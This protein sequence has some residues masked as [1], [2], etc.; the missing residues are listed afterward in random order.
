MARRA[1]TEDLPDQPTAEVEPA[2]R[3]P[4]GSRP[5]VAGLMLSM[6]LV[7][8]DGTVVSTAMPSIISDLGGFKFYAWVPA[9]Y[10]LCAA[11][12][13][14]IY[15]KLADLFGRKPILYV[16]IGLFLAGSITSGAAP[17]VLFL[18][19]ARS[20]QGLGAGAV[21][22]IT[23]TI[24]GDIFSL[25]QRA[26]IQGVFSSVWGVSS[27]IGPLVGGLFVDNVGWRWIFYVNIPFAILAILLISRFFREK[28]VH[29]EHKLDLA[30]ATLLSFGLSAILLFL[31]EGGQAWSWVS[32]QSGLLLAL[33]AVSLML[34]L[35]QELRA[36]EPTLPLDLF[37]SR[38]ISVSALGTFF[39]GV[40]LISVSYEV[41]LFVQGVLGLDA[42]HAGVAL[43]PMSI[44]WPLAGAVS[45]KLAIRFGYRAISVVGLALDIV[46]VG[47]LLTLGPSSS[48]LATSVYSFVIGI[49]LGLCSAPMLIAVQSSVPW[50]RRGVATATIMFVRSF[51]SVV[52][53]AI[54]GAIVYRST[55]RYAG[56]SATNQELS[57]HLRSRLPPAL[58]QHIRDALFSGIHLAFLAAL[59]AAIAG[60]LVVSN[61]PG[62]SALEHE[63]AETPAES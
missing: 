19:A 22:P 40:V 30:G 20:L 58:L 34:F 24:I 50:A 63:L 36:D 32:A 52:G 7:A 28:K 37:R 31:I 15:G 44:G 18:I 53:L 54:M 45:G 60:T 27:V 29:R 51:G 21:Q 41:P 47:L 13:T 4:P 9:V 10:L 59:V 16:G 8:L 48:Y 38:I 14:P 49:G 57:I 11:V 25:E 12:T 6:S 62:G 61:L 1:L 55:A 23:M 33:T 5:V 2:P 56:S 26:R 35:R 3:F 42:L 43:A 17:N 46:G 39:A